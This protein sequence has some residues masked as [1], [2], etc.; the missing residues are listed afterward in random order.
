MRVLFVYP[1]VRGLYMLPPAVAILSALL[2]QEGHDCRLFDTTYWNVPEAGADSEAH[3]ERHLHVRPYEKNPHEVTLKTTDVYEEFNAVVD[4]FRPQLIAVSCTEDL[5]PFAINLLG[6][7]RDKHGAKTII[8]GIFAT[9]APDKCI[10]YPEIDIV[11]IGEGEIPLTE[12]CRR[13][14]TGKSYLFVPNLWVKHGGMV[15]KNPLGKVVDI[16]AT[17]LLDLDIFEQARFYRPFD[18]KIYK[19]FPVETHRGCPYRC[20]YC[21]SPMQMDLYKTE[22]A[23]NF[24]RLKT[25]ENVRKELR[26]YK[27]GY[28]AE[29]MYFWAD[30]FLALSDKYLQELAE[31]YESEIGLPFWCQTRPETL[32]EKRVKLL[33]KMGCHRVGVGVEHGN[34][35]FR[36]QMLDRRV[37]NETIVSGLRIL[38]DY[39]IKFSVNNIVGFPGETRELAFDTIRLNR[40]IGA[41]TRNMYTFVP[42]HGTALRE[43]AVKKGFIDEALI[44]TSLTQPTVL[45]MPQFTPTEID[46]LKRCFVPYV[47]LEEDRW[48][49]IRQAEAFTPE[50][51]AVWDRLI[52]ECRSRFFSQ[53]APERDIDPDLDRMTAGA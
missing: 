37:S 40:L 52:E 28:G 2:K 41:D 29:Y 24:F 53:Y 45:N 50:G 43:I 20:A 14:E 6:R 26:Y 30:T 11:C 23:D 19:T 31:M 1:N 18:G 17:P 15:Q 9:F 47:M 49:E 16:E 44:V 5:F 33:K 21:N 46:G 10:R 34:P 27:D 38:N 32:T 12:L 51:N 7:L 4:D 13:M 3:K 48:P 25:V 39:D 35:Q 42:F 36:E 22:A 8:G